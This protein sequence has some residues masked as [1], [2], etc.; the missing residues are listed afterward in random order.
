MIYKDNGGASRTKNGVEV[1]V[2]VG[3]DPGSADQHRMR[4]EPSVLEPRGFRATFVQTDQTPE[5]CSP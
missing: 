2:E 1:G 5:A 4:C 3:D